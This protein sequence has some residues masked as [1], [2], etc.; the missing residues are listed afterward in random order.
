MG[1]DGLIWKQLGQ[2]IDGEAAGENS[3]LS[4]SLSADELVMIRV[5]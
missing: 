2:D 5:M 1:G 3:G 4:V